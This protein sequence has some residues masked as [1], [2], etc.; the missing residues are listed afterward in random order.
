MHGITYDGVWTPVSPGSNL[1]AYWRGQS[2]FC[3]MSA[4]RA[5]RACAR[6]WMLCDGSFVV[7]I[8]KRP[9]DHSSL[10]QCTTSM[11]ILA[12]G[13]FAETPYFDHLERT[14]MQPQ[15]AMWAS[16]GLSMRTI[17]V[18]APLCIALE[19]IATNACQ[20]VVPPSSSF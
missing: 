5:F 16:S 6:Y 19:V 7:N 18:H 17:S 8:S 9:S 14:F 12:N 4:I 20:L 3:S 11:N 15:F 1:C 13:R 10:R 2:S